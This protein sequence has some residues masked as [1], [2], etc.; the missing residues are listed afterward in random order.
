MYYKTCDH[1]T[2]LSIVEKQDRE[3]KECREF[4]SGSMMHLNG[5]VSE[6]WL[7]VGRKCLKGGE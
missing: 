3:L 7:N 5:R 6:E 1:K 4:I 2:L